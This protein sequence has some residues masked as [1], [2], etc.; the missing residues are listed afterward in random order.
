MDPQVCLN[1]LI[2]AV[3][4]GDKDEAAERLCDLLDWRGNKSGFLPDLGVAL[5]T[6]IETI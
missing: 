4:R 6:L 1:E 2:R 3:Y 5:K